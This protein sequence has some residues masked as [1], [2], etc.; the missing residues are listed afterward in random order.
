MGRR[1]KKITESSALFSV[2]IEED[3]Y[4]KIQALLYDAQKVLNSG[5]TG[6]TGE[7]AFVPKGDI[8]GA[9]LVIGLKKILMKGKL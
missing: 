1:R 5:W 3:T 7:T 2:R 9:A 6:P 4:K 8:V